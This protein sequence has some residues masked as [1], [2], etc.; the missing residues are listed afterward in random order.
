MKLFELVALSV[1]VAVATYV[2]VSPNV[3]TERQPF[4]ATVNLE[5]FASNALAD[6]ATVTVAYR[7]DGSKS[8][9]TTMHRPDSIPTRSIV[10]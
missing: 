1:L 2:V 4:T 10:S 5:Y 9:T 6:T 3:A 8:E 7:Q